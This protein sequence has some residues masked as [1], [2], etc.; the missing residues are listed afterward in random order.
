MIKRVGDL[1]VVY[2]EESTPIFPREKI[3]YL[4]VRPKQTKSG[5]VYVF[6]DA[7]TTNEDP[8]G[9]ELFVDLQDPESEDGKA[10]GLAGHLVEEDLPENWVIS[11]RTLNRGEY[12][13]DDY[14]YNAFS[15]V[16]TELAGRLEIFLDEDGQTVHFCL[17]VA[18][19]VLEATASLSDLAEFLY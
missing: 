10:V 1:M 9:L 2:P 8:V 19:K 3:R 17:T 12:C 15:E 11:L 14:L 7:L 6:L 16:I 5:E 13:R 4:K 18:G